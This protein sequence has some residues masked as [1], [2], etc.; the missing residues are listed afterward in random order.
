MGLLDRVRDFF[1][2]SKGQEEAAQ[3]IYGGNQVDKRDLIDEVKDLKRRVLMQNSFNT[4]AMRVP[5]Y[6]LEQ[7]S[8]E[9][10]TQIRDSLQSELGT[11]NRN[12][13]A[14][15]SKE[16]AEREAREAARW[17]GNRPEGM[18][19]QDLDRAQRWER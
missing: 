12:N 5:E 19:Q 4:T 18:S 17:T 8:I 9:E 1:S 15:S 2:G 10:L 13:R 11:I 14:A 16:R 3:I 6:G 7:K